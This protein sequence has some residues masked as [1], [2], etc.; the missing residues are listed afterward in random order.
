MKNRKDKLR[1]GPLVLILILSI[2]V[3]I[4]TI[5][6]NWQIHIRELRDHVGYEFARLIQERA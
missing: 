3:G 2:V 6:V 5:R 4:I 1:L